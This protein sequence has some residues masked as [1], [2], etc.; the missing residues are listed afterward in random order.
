[1][2]G[3]RRFCQASRRD[4]SACT[5]PALTSNGYQFCFAHDPAALEARKRGGHNRA[6]VI[7]LRRLAPPALVGVYSLLEEALREVH[8]GKL[9]PR[10]ASAMASLA[11]AMTRVLTYGELEERLRR[12]ED[13]RGVTA[14]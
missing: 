12:L 6:T 3:D 9:D 2:T 1:M 8:G 14:L 10:V 7:R 11:T 5:L 4:G 13:G